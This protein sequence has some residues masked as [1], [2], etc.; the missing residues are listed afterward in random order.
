MVFTAAFVAMKNACCAAAATPPID[1]EKAV[2]CDPVT[3]A[4]VLVI[5]A[6]DGGIPT[7]A[8]YNADGTAYAGAIGALTACDTP[9][10]ESD[11]VQYCDGGLVPFLRWFIKRDGVITGSVDTDL[12][13]ISYAPAGSITV[14][15]CPAVPEF[16][17]ILVYMERNGGTVTV[18]DIVAS[19]GAI[20]V[21]SITVKQISGR[22]S[23]A[24]DSGSGV[25][26]DA[27]ET[28]S[29]SAISPDN[30]DTMN[31]SALT[32]DAGGGEQRI[33]ATYSR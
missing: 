19:T 18:A 5:T 10:I 14:G 17:E 27:G 31:A 21:H 7:P 25:P 28:W 23:V 8:A 20:A 9:E 32:L 15:I 3:G 2:L 16:R 12:A 33:T 22:G 30:T 4:P 6:I 13:G 1:Y 26:L 29:W 11:P 24:A